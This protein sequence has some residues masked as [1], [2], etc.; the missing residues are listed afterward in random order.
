M[1]IL[2]HTFL[3]LLTP[4]EREF[5]A[6]AHPLR[7]PHWHLFSK[8]RTEDMLGVPKGLDR[9]AAYGFRS[10]IKSRH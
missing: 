1:E 4:T 8:I 5:F 10:R 2:F 7:Q 6:A 9:K 3:G